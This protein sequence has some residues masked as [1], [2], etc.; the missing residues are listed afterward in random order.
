[1]E[2]RTEEVVNLFESLDLPEVSVPN[3]DRLSF[4]QH[5]T[6]L[7]TTGCRSVVWT[8]WARCSTVTEFKS[9]I[10]P[11]AVQTS[12][13]VGHVL[14]RGDDLVHVSSYRGLQGGARCLTLLQQRLVLG[15][16][17]ALH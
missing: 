2:N 15:L 11:T 4:P 6:L 3:E 14:F 16:A 9:Y 12:D 5:S 10:R 1:M 17:L 13:L 8:C 7:G